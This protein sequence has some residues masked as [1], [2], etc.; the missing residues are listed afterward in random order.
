MPE[1]IT[2]AQALR[3]VKKLKGFIAEHRAR[4]VAGVSYISDKVPAFRF[5]DEVAAMSELTKELI[6]LE[7]R[8]ATANATATIKDGEDEMTLSKAIRTLQELKG[9]ISFYQ[10]LN[11]RDGIEKNRESTWDDDL[12]KKITR[13]EE[14]LWVCDLSEAERDRN[15]KSLQDRFEQLNNLVED[16][17]HQIII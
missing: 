10:L 16:A 9:V 15:V 5:A 14:I 13:V 17:N 6:D 8:I 4:A 2:I 12:G 3:R 1:R 7:A 11:L